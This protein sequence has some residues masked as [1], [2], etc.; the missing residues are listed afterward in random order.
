MH[1]RYGITATVDELVKQRGRATHVRLTPRRRVRT[2]HAGGYDSAFRGRG[3]EFDEARIYQPGDDLRTIDWRV[4]ARTGRVHTKLFHEERERPVLLLVDQ[5]SPMRFG[6]RD[7][8]KSVLAARAAATLAW[9]ARDAGD[10]VGA[11]LLTD[12]GCREIAPQRARGR[13]LALLRSLSDSTDPSPAEPPSGRLDE[14]A[15]P[16]ASQRSSVRSDAP[17]RPPALADALTRLAR[18]Q[19]PGALVLVLSDFHDLD[20][21]VERELARLAARCELGCIFVFDGLEAAAPGSGEYRVSDGQRVL[22]LSSA[23]R[24]WRDEYAR[25]FAER[26]ERLAALCRR[27]GVALLPLRTG[28]DPAEVLRADRFGRAFGARKTAAGGIRA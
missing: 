4:T 17:A 15:P 2:L 11:F 10:R 24:R 16:D 14:A 6:T 20:D 7:A 9:A 25:A 3:L 28:D 27:R 13:L 22:R 19:R 23:D 5:R 1:E 18:V 12:A 21:A 26:R 8:F